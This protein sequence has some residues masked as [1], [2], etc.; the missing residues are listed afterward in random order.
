MKLD[1]GC[2][3]PGELNHR[4]RSIDSEHTKS[5]PVSGARPDTTAASEINEKTLGDAGALQDLEQAGTGFD[6]ELSE[7]C[8]V[9]VGEVGLVV[10]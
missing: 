5:S 1:A 4:R 10:S 6:D 2:D 9:N 8:M 3:A 7:A